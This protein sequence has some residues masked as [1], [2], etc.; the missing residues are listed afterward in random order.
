MQGWKGSASINDV[1][2]KNALFVELGDDLQVK[3]DWLK[4]SDCQIVMGRV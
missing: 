1:T 4:S 3:Y 2:I